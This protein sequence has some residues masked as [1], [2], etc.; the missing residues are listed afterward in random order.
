[1]WKDG[2]G[3]GGG[4]SWERMRRLFGDTS[5]ISYAVS[6]RPG[7]GEIVTILRVIHGA[8]K[9]AARRTAEIRIAPARRDLDSYRVGD[10]KPCVAGGAAFPVAHRSGKPCAMSEAVE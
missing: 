8:R 4:E 3:S 5:I 7:G 10:V 9:L 2:D 1:M 6:P